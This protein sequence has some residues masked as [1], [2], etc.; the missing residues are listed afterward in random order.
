MRKIRGDVDDIPL[1]AD[2]RRQQP[3]REEIGCLDVEVDVL[4]EQGFI[5]ICKGREAPDAGVV[6]QYIHVG[7]AGQHG[8]CHVLHLLRMLQIGLKQM[9]TGRLVM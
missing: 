5:R 9:N 2:Q 3:L 8:I 4:V 6:D 7:P 1:G